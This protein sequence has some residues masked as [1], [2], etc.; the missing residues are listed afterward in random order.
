MEASDGGQCC[1]ESSK[2]EGMP[3]KWG[4]YNFNSVLNQVFRESLSK[5]L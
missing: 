3:G 2:A 4:R 1:T 5:K